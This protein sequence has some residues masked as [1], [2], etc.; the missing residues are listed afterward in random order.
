MIKRGIITLKVLP[1][2]A[3]K[4]ITITAGTCKF[5][6]LMVDD[7]N[8]T[9]ENAVAEDL[10]PPYQHDTT[11]EV[12]NAIPPIANYAVN[13][14]SGNVP[15]NVQFTDTSSNSPTSWL[16]NFGDGGTSTQQNPSHIYTTSGTY[17]VTLTATNSVG[18]NTIIKNKLITVTIQSSKNPKGPGT[19][20]GIPGLN[21]PNDDLVKNPGNAQFNA[22]INNITASKDKNPLISSQSSGGGG[23][24]GKAS[25]I[26]ETPA[27]TS[28]SPQNTYTY[29][30]AVL[31]IIGTV[32]AGY[33]YEMKDK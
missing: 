33:L 13:T 17:S 22:A 27:N 24:G 19:T 18:N 2:D 10:A 31:L 21:P 7:I 25:E 4:T 1:Q 8:G 9:V 32:V 12:A 5:I 23:G 28:N 26:I 6:S 30:L 29:F 15:L 3:G 14:T 20:T 16:W 11:L